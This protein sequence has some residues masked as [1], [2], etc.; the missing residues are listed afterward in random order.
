MKM[1]AIPLGLCQCGCGRR[2]T[3]SRRNDS[4]RGYVRGRHQRYVRG[5]SSG[6][7]QGPRYEVCPDTECWIWLGAKNAG[8][9]GLINVNGKS[10]LAHRWMFEQIVGPIPKDKVID[11][12]CRNQACVNP[13]HLEV[14]SNATNCR[15][16][17]RPRLSMAQAE[18]IRRLATEHPQY[19]HRRI[20]GM[21]ATDH[22][23]IGRILKG[24]IWDPSK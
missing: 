21:Y 18:E 15:R 11:H 23:T 17:N 13:E 12:L 22:R 14:V 3:I 9:Y 10:R 2:T 7:W 4:S 16:G 20:A 5:H 8:G 1:A 24:E 19:S 6:C